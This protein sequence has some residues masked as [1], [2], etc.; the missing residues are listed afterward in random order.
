MR[1][2]LAVL[3]AAGLSATG[4]ANAQAPT[5]PAPPQPTPLTAAEC[6][7]FAR[8]ASFAKAAADHDAAAFAAH[9]HPGA[10]FIDGGNRVVR[11]R[12]GVAADWAPIIAGK[13]IVLRWHPDA[14]T[15]AGDPDIALSR[16]PYWMEN[17]APG[18]AQ[19]YLVGRFISTWV[20]NADGV[21]Q[22]LFDG[23]AGGRPTPASAA[24]VAKLEAAARAV[25]PA[26]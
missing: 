12:A 23:G 11:G 21:W 18:A 16:G 5:A 7:V 22:V 4:L 17:R 13:D 8:E 20:R 15:I 6:E 10:A 3:L 24:D 14:V 9:L 26:A 19:P 25:C 2:V 1:P